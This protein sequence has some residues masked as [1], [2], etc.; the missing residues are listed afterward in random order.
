M[1]AKLLFGISFLKSL[2]LQVLG[3]RYLYKYFQIIKIELPCKEITFEG[4]TEIHCTCSNLYVPCFIPCQRFYFGTEI[5][6]FQIYLNL[7]ILFYISGKQ[8]VNTSS[9]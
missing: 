5:N 9:T 7:K 4:T 2:N 8:K 6:I 1:S 3:W